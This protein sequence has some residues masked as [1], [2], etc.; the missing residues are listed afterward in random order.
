MKKF[1]ATLLSTAL[2][3]NAITPILAYESESTDVSEKYVQE[4]N[5]ETT[6]NEHA[7]DPIAEAEAEQAYRESANFTA[8]K[9]V[10]A[11]RQYRQDGVKFGYLNDSSPMLDGLGLKNVAYIM[12]FESDIADEKSGYTAYDVYYEAETSEDV[13]L[14]VDK[15]NAVEGIVSAEP[16][17]VWNTAEN[18][19]A[20]TVSGDEIKNAWFLDNDTHDIK[21]VW[22]K[23]FTAKAPGAGTVVAVIDTGVDY[24]H[25]DLAANMWVNDGEIPDNGIDDDGNGYIDDYRG[26]N[27]IT[28]G[29][30]PEQ[31]N[32][33]DDMGHGTHVSGIIAMTPGNG[34]GV[35]V[36]YG[37]KIMAIKAGQATGTF[38]STD[39]AKAIKYAKNNGADVINMSFGGTGKSNLVESAL[40]DAFGQCV[41][42][43]S[44]GNDGLPTTDHP[45]PCEDIYPG[46]YKYVIGVMAEDASG[47][48]AGFSNWDYIIGKNCEYEIAAPGVGIY[49]TLPN[50]KY[51][52]WSGTSMAAPIVAAEAAII[53]SYRPDKNY[54]T[55]RYIIGQIVSATEDVA[56]GNP[57]QIHYNSLTDERTLAWPSINIYDSIYKQPKPALNF[58]EVYTLDSK[59]LSDTNNGNGI[60]QSGETVD[61]AFSVFNYWGIAGDVR[62]KADAN[63]IADIPNPY[64]EFIT[65]TAKLDNIGTFATVNNGYTYEN[66]ELVSVSKPIRLKIKDNAPNDAEI[67]INLT[68]TASNDMDK[69][70]KNVYSCNYTYTFRVQ[71]GHALSGVIKED[72]TLTSD[73][74]WII[75]NAVR[76]PEGVTVTVEPGA[77]I[78]FWSND[79]SN[80][81]ADEAIVYIQ[82]DGKFICNGTYEKPISMFPGKGYEEYCVELKREDYS[83]TYDKRYIKLDYVNI[84]NPGTHD[85]SN[86]C[87]ASET[88]HCNFYQSYP[89]LK[90]RY[91]NGNEIKE[92]WNNGSRFI[93]WNIKNSKFNIKSKG[94]NNGGY[95]YSALGWVNAD[96]LLLDNCVASLNGS[97]GGFGAKIE[98]SVFLLDANT[99]DK[100][101]M[102]LV[103]K[104]MYSDPKYKNN[105]LLNNLNN[106]NVSD[107]FRVYAYNFPRE[108]ADISGNYWGTE[109]ENLIKKQIYD[110]DWNIQYS[111][112][113]HTPWLTLES[114]SLADIYPFVTKVYLTDK[115]GNEVT[116]VSGSQ[117]V[118]FHVLFNRDMASD[119]QPDVTFGGSE[120]FTDYTVTGDWASAREWQGTMTIDPFVNQGR[121]YMRIK[122]AAAADDKWLVTGDDHERFFFDVTKSDAQAMALQGVGLLGKNQ[123]SW[124]QDDYETLAGYN[125]YRSTSY[126]PSVDVSEQNFTKINTSVIPY[127]TEFYEDTDV[128]SGVKYY[129]YFTVVDTDFNQSQPSNI[130]DVTPLDGNPPVI[131]H[132]AVKSVEEGKALS[133]QACV[134]D[135]VIVTGAA[136]YY[137]CDEVASGSGISDWSSRELNNVSGSSYQVKIPANEITGET[138]YYY[139]IAGDGTNTAYFGTPAEPI[140]VTVVPEGHSVHTY[141]NGICVVCG[142]HKAPEQN[143]NE[144]YEIG[145]AGELFAFAELV[146]SGGYDVNAVLTDD[147]VLSGSAITAPD[148]NTP[149]WTPIG[150]S[151]LPFSGS[152]DG[153]YHKITGLYVNTDA[154]YAGLFG[155]TN[156]A[157]IKNIGIENS[158]IKGGSYTGALVGYT[159][160]SN[161]AITNCYG[162]NNT[163][164]GSDYTGGLA[165]SAE[166]SPIEE[167]FNALGSVTGNNYVGGIA[168]YMY[169]SDT[170]A[171][172]CYSTAA[173][174]GSSYV[175]GIAGSQSGGLLRCYFLDTT[176]KRSGVSRTAEKF[177]NGTV[178]F[179]LNDSTDGGTRWYQNIDKGEA[180]SLPVIAKF[181]GEHHEVYNL[182]SAYSNYRKGDLDRN[183]RVNK[184]DANILLHALNDSISEEDFEENYHYKAADMNDD[185]EMNILD[186]IIILQET[187]E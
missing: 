168:G 123:L 146:N 112:L 96:N 121:M 44:A 26:V 46:G 38:A 127:G 8:G 17:F 89:T 113:N 42:V 12:D 66:D 68:V 13:W 95:Y 71:K 153:Q 186:A 114:E 172:Y 25:K 142:A 54:Y 116:T 1:V 182:A 124:Y 125:L 143:D 149:V 37:A 171:Q 179:S 148:E 174:S 122:G 75:E 2:L 7:Y 4:A 49:S 102:V 80:I 67:A 63:S 32:P 105:A 57:L 65:D 154:D 73:E 101:Q 181:G 70:D 23:Y 55:N 93:S 61:L 72:M 100:S 41:L 33:M 158:Y 43:A 147:I 177:A 110:A 85:G 175:G 59:E 185:A 92:D 120:P 77:Q 88:N 156:N 90:R 131:T 107:W 10:F 69:T 104:D 28:N 166:Y 50:N 170:A 18:G 3:L 183:D 173:I 99:N 106:M 152:F 157:E 111:D 15:L 98:N 51:A 141:K 11:V 150:S 91:I 109:N 52:L 145:S 53:R 118:T 140:E 81:Y 45:E 20:V 35:G 108:D 132:T 119:I 176:A 31:N 83:L 9:V 129:Y 47:N 19:D 58:T 136:V 78:Q 151:S 5:V 24:T 29:T 130:I 6:E 21:N 86:S 16:D 60:I 160:N 128:E 22:N 14:T 167:S 126:D 79:P 163:V 94:K 155:Y 62:V 84:F 36:A 134:T 30:Y 56:Y 82:V 178:A 139:L 138:L 76:I 159:Y 27:F 64:V 184:T 164:I 161:G 39:I 162:K 34:G 180:D 117:E 133:I 87:S 144:C 74:Y 115:D 137:R 187:N 103:G 97:V 40:K 165:G 135:D 48:L 169:H